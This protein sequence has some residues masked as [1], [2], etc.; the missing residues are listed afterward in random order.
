M[1]VWRKILAHGLKRLATPV[2]NQLKKLSMSKLSIFVFFTKFLL[3]LNHSR[4]TV[5]KIVFNLKM[6]Y[7]KAT[8]TF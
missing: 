7:T 1:F 8:S 4:L 3:K 2:L 5:R 6:S